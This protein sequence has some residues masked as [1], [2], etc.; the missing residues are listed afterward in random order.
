MTR[1]PL[2][3]DAA[4]IGR[5]ALTVADLEATAAF[6]RDVVGLSVLAET[7]TTATLGVDG[8]ALLVLR[9]DDDAP[10]RTDDRAGLFH[11]AFRVPSRA[12]LGATLERIRDRSELSGASDHYVS[13]ALYLADP[14][15]NG[16]EVYADR[17]RAEWPRTEDGKIGIGTVSLDLDD[18]VSA[19][20]G[21]AAAPPGTTVG[22]V[23]LEATSLSASRAFYADTLGLQ[24]QTESPSAL[25]LAAGDYHHHLGVNVWNGRSRPADGRG[26]AWFE[27]LVPDEATLTT[28]RRGLAAADASVTEREAGFEVE[29]PSGI[30][31]RFR[32]E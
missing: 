13:E 14:E 20:D 27:F 17:P 4:R 18:L 31:V 15:G 6:Y 11:N 25:F 30:A 9:R 32:A 1:T 28:V 7:E 22:H 24:V 23:H 3:P 29:D 5:T 8:T 10:P 21:A 19:S 2:V 26:V 16:V 12:A